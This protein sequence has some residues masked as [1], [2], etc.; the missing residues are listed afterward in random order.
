MI[1]HLNKKYQEF[2]NSI[3]KNGKKNKKSKSQAKKNKNTFAIASENPF[4]IAFKKAEA[5]FFDNIEKNI[6]LSVKKT[7]K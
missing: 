3:N 2:L 6:W 1:E 7:K 4:V 5:R